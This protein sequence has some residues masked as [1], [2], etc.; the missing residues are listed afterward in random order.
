M[1]VV[2][3]KHKEISFSSFSLAKGKELRGDDYL[4]VKKLDEVVV[5]VL[6]DGVGSADE[7]REAAKRVVTY[8]INNFKNR[9]KSWPI[10]K[11]LK[12]FITS[13][14]KI[15]Y[16]E[17]LA[18]YERE[19]L[20]TTLALVVIDNDRLYGANVGDSR[21]YL[22]RDDKLIL[23]SLDHSEDNMLFEAI[24]M[25]EEINIHYF[26]NNL[27]KDD[28]ILLCSDGLYNVLDENEIK[29]LV[30][31]GAYNLVKAA[32]KKTNDNLPDDTSAIVIKIEDLAPINR[33]KKLDLEISES[34]KKEQI[35]DGYKLIKPLIQNNR[36]WLVEKK[37]QKYIMKFPLIE[38]K[39]D[40]TLLDQYIKE[41]WN[42]LRL[43]A[44]FFPK[45]VIPKKRSFRYYIQE[46]IDGGNLKEYKK[47]LHIDDA[48]NLG[49]T[50][51]NATQYLL[52]FN[53]VHADIKPENIIVTKRNDKLIFKIIDFG[54]ITEIYSINT[55]AGTP[56]YL[57]PERFKDSLINESTEIFA[58][59]VTLY[60]V[61]TNK[62]PFG[63][64]EPFS[65][66]TFKYPKEPKKLNPK[67]PDWLN[68]VILRAIE[69][70]PQKRYKHYSEM[71]F[72]LTNPD[73]V[74][75]YFDPT[76]SL[77][78]KEPAKAYKIA[79]FVSLIVNFLFL[80]FLL[81]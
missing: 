36:T 21:I 41:A 43:K 40:E 77:I 73:K 65:N 24:G 67:I 70:N 66:P 55:K 20:L 74:K 32:S 52:K 13:I 54:N 35:I 31:L 7:G 22:K 3:S 63:E 47:P 59:G 44:G 78:E 81:K 42:A 68:S 14:N 17:S 69:I 8:L 64:I 48:I 75:P 27:Q 12:T 50:L 30:E 79:F 29:R 2:E 34:L 53:L 28:T 1:Q 15:L 51:L 18:L 10:K 45:A 46:Y 33:L 61:L 56:S 49:K 71:L 25:K 37:N 76:K 80:Y 57:A 38:A 6:C 9:I 26:E 11:T 72:E 58:I 23:L 16:N 62:L 60:E 39:Y 4:D 19:E 5:A